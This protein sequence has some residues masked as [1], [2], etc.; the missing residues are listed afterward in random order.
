MAR[1]EINN[2]NSYEVKPEETSK[3]MRQFLEIKKQNPNTLLLYRMGDFYE[4]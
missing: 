2:I 3:G 1:T 4:T